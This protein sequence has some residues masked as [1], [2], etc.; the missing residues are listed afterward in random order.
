[1]SKEVIVNVTELDNFVRQVLI[2]HGLNAEDARITAEVLIRA[3]RRGIGSH[4][5]ARLKRYVDGLDS[6]VIRPNPDVK[7]IRE[8]PVSLVIDGDGGMG[9]PIAYRAMQKCIEKARTAYMCF[10]AI[11][12]SNHYGIAGYYVLMA[13]AEGMMGVSLTNTT[14]LV[15]PTF[16]RNVTIGTNPIAIG[17]PGKKERPFLLDMATSTVPRGKLEVYARKGEPIP[18]CW[19]CDEDGKPS[20]DAAALLDDMIN[21]RV[22]GLLP[23]GGGTELTGG[24][25]GYGL[26]AVVDILCGVLSAGMVG[27]EVARY[28]NAP[29]GVSHFIGAINPDAFV[30][31]DLIG[32]G[33][34]KYIQMLRNAD[35]AAG[36]ER[37]YVAGEKEFLAEERYRDF[38]PLQDKVFQTLNDI[39]TKV[40]LSITELKKER[41]KCE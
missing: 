3:D 13:L 15:V 27:T 14:P 28:S 21:R 12:N 35:K 38:V 16:G 40:G 34:D 17:F 31:T 18:D 7:I 24:H 10:A 33:I 1:M 11:R 36:Q 8:T 22:G 23:L 2:A 25:K 30:G 19:A 5:V 9:Q 32:E 20:T 6:G 37:I 39:G 29:A 4:G 41:T 26:S